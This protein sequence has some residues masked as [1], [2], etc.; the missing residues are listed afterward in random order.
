MSI[1]AIVLTLIV[2]GILLWLVG[3]IPMDGRILQIIRGVVILFVVI[4]LVQAIFPG[5]TAG[6]GAGCNRPIVVHTR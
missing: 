2:V 5:V 4:W 3:F 1:I 6:F